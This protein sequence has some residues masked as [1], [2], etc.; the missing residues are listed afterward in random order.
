MKKKNVS[1]T[2][3]SRQYFSVTIW[4][5]PESNQKKNVF[6][7]IWGEKILLYIITR[8]VLCN[9][10]NFFLLQFVERKSFYFDF[11]NFFFTLMSLQGLRTN[12]TSINKRMKNKQ[13]EDFRMFL[14]PVKILKCLSLFNLY[15]PVCY[16]VYRFCLYLTL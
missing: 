10:Q 15:P 6:T 3:I 7:S 1:I 8:N 16:M 5:T 4:L 12:Q 2:S 9:F 13:K 14:T 11:Q